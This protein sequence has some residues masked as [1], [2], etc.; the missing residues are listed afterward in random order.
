MSSKDLTETDLQY[1]RRCVASLVERYP[2]LEH[3]RAAVAD[4]AELLI[5]C[6]SRSGTVLTCGNGGSAAD[7]GHIVG[8]L[9]KG[10]RHKRPISDGIAKRFSDGDADLAKGLIGSLQAPL[11][12][13]DL[14][15][16]AALITAFVND[17][18]A[19]TVYAQQVLGYSSPENLL[20]AIST[21][22]N[23]RNIVYAAFAARSLGLSVIG[24]TGRSGG[25]LS[26]WCDVCIS[27]PADETAF[28]QE[29]HLPVYHALCEIAEHHF[30]PD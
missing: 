24:L 25:D 16:Q 29:L 6:Y 12:A 17:R 15:A 11:P 28:V 7:A 1:R 3:C 18:A 13:I 4:S 27:V 26:R 14:T 9:M 22:G 19:E 2:A 20:I 21:S 5:R 8:E 30:F 23:S 10:F